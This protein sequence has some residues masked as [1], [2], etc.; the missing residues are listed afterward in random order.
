M[1]NILFTLIILFFVNRT[2]TEIIRCDDDKHADVLC[3]QYCIA[4]SKKF[5]SSKC[6]DDHVATCVCTEI[7]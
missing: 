3:K 7:V 5:D 2:Q 1:K 4:Q 6:S